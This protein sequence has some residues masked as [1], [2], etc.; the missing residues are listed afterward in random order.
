VPGLG[1]LVVG[2]E[3][4]SNTRHSSAELLVNQEWKIYA[5]FS[6]LAS[7]H[8]SVVLDNRDMY[9]IGGFLENEPFSGK[10]LIFNLKTGNSYTIRS[11]MKAGRQLH[12]CAIIDSN[13]IIVAGGRNSKGLVKTVEVFYTSTSR[14]TEMK[15][16]EF[17][18]GRG[19]GQLLT[20][21]KKA[22]V[23]SPSS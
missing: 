6:V 19:Y 21:G 3:L 15:N 12:S 17:K 23:F 5:N 7:Q 11:Q 20:V 2:G 13:K 16:L 1:L 22:S 14:W 9:V 8:C 10:T 4:N 18:I